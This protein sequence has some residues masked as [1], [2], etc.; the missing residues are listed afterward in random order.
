MELLRSGRLAADH[1]DWEIGWGFEWQKGVEASA[2]EGEGG[3]AGA[4]QEAVVI[5]SNL[6]CKQASK[7]NYKVDMLCRHTGLLPLACNWPTPCTVR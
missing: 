7:A 5:A 4:R 6:L 1:Y 3:E 2:A